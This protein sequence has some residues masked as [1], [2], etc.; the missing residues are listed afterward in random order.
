MDRP[1][2]SVVIPH[3]N[4]TQYVERALHSV[5]CQRSA[6]YLVEVIV[7]DDGSN[8]EAKSALRDIVARQP[9]LHKLSIEWLPRNVGGG[10]ARNHGIAA[11]SGD[12][13]A[14]LDSDD[15]WHPEKLHSQIPF[16]LERS[17]D[18]SATQFIE[19]FPN[20]RRMQLPAK[21]YVSDMGLYLFN[22]GGHFQ[23]STL[24][25]KRTVAQN[26][27]FD[28]SLKKF[29]D[30]NFAIRLDAGRHKGATLMTPLANYYSDHGGRISSEASAQHTS[31]FFQCSADMLS[32]AARFSFE[33]RILPTALIAERRTWTAVAT[34]LRSFLKYR[35]FSPRA[36]MSVPK[37]AFIRSIA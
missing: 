6:N 27:Q 29:Q 9:K 32:E 24:V 37:Q 21:S 18:F 28:S 22:E 4:R 8:E 26:V 35:R 2:I 1:C 3:Y 25:V 17:L 34:I 5:I 15:E 7:V 14:F 10:A 20:G 36:L 33:S 30:W 23:T 19:I 31:R 12:Y 11:S 13:I 16:M